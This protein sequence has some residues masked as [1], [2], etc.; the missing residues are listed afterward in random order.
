MQGVRNKQR[1]IHSITKLEYR[2]GLPWWYTA[3]PKRRKWA[4]R[5]R[6]YRIAPKLKQFYKLQ[7]LAKR[8]FIPKL[9]W[10]TPKVE[11]SHF[12]TTHSLD[13]GQFM[14]RCA[15]A[16]YSN[17]KRKPETPQFLPTRAAY[18]LNAVQPD[19]PLKLMTIIHKRRPIFH[20]DLCAGVMAPGKLF[21][22]SI[23]K[24]STTTSIS[25]NFTVY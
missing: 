3:C 25:M 10:P 20:R 21:V 7:E 12:V 14:M 11:E 18:I 9:T 15:A 8:E 22:E 4:H 24:S 19:K 16:L 17:A 5:A 6:R 23:F 13:I 1:V 2:Q